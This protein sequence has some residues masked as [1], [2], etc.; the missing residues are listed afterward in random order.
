MVIPW[1][2]EGTESM[3]FGFDDVDA[4][5]GAYTAS[6]STEL[7]A[8]L[9][10]FLDGL[11]DSLEQLG[12]LQK[13]QKDEAGLVLLKTFDTLRQSIAYS[14]PELSWQDCRQ[15]LGMA[16]ESQHFTPPANNSS[17]QLITLEQAAFL[18]FDCVIIAAA[19]SQHFPGSAKNSP[20]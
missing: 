13:Y 3:T 11:L 18:H 5:D 17:V 4:A 10:E 8:M 6:F 7:E 12:A 16:L 14:N 15:W 20:G 9:P 19:E 2:E 1:D